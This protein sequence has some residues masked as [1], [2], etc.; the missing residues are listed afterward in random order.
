MKKQGVLIYDDVIGRMDIRFGPLDYYGGLHCGERLEVLLDGE[1][2]PTRIELGEFWY[3]HNTFFVA[4]DIDIRCVWMAYIQLSLYGIP[5][6]VIH[7]NTLTMEEWDRW[8][9]P[10]ASVPFSKAQGKDIIYKSLQNR[11]DCTI[12]NLLQIILTDFFYIVF[13]YYN[14]K[15][16]FPYK[17]TNSNGA[18]Q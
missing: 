9:T 2:I 5:A 7:G 14:Q 12:E 16:P 6:M 17:N 3:R 18:F 11:L 13:R 4:Q 8:Y 1:W 15:S 10:Y